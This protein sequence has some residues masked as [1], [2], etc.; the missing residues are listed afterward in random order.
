MYREGVMDERNVHKSCRLFNEGRTDVHIEEWP[1]DSF[2][3]TE[4][5]KDCVDAHFREN[6]RFTI[7]ELQEVFP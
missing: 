5:L 2:V 1:G 4:D 3:F 7:H 6:R